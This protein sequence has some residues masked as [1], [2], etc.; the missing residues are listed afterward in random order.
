[1]YNFKISTLKHEANNIHTYI[2][3][4]TTIRVDPSTTSSPKKIATKVCKLCMDG[5]MYQHIYVC[6]YVC[7]YV[8]NKLIEFGGRKKKHLQQ[9]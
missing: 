7:M 3:Y 1:M 8:W 9:M 4:T 5:W 6:M 2:L